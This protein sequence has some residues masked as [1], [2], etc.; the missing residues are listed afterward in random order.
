MALGRGS[1][2]MHEKLLLGVRNCF[3]AFRLELG[4]YGFDRTIAASISS[5]CRCFAPIGYL[6]L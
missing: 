5:C 6:N 2:L 1:K 4:R 3:L